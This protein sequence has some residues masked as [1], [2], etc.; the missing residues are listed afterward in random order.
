MQIKVYQVI[1]WDNKQMKVK[2]LT[3]IWFRTISLF[4]LGFF[5]NCSVFEY[6]FFEMY[7]LT[8]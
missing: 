7:V 1:D 4:D 5:R 2:Q 3:V 8:E 6:N